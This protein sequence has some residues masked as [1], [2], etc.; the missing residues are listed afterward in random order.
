LRGSHPIG[1]DIQQEF[2]NFLQTNADGR[3]TAVDG[4]AYRA[5][6]SITLLPAALTQLTG[7]S[8]DAIFRIIFPLAFALYPL[9]VF[10]LARRFAATPAAF[11][12]AAII[13][14]QAHFA[15]QLPAVARQ[16][17]AFLFFGALLT[18]IFSSAVGKRRDVAVIVCGACLVVS[19]YSTAY[20]TLVALIATL[21]VV[22]LV[23]I[24]RRAYDR[25]SGLN[26]FPVVSLVLIAVAWYGPVTHSTGNVSKFVDR[27]DQQQTASSS[28]TSVDRWINGS[29]LGPLSAEEFF[30]KSVVAGKIDRPWAVTYPEEIARTSPAVDDKAAVVKERSKP[31]KLFSIGL[32]VLAAQSYVL[33]SVAAVLC[34]AWRHRRG[35]TTKNWD[36]A[37]LAVVMLGLVAVVRV[38]DTVGQ[39]YNPERF[40]IQAATVLSVPIAWMVAA[41]FVRRPRIVQT[42][43]VAAV[44][45]MFFNGSGMGAIL[46]GG[47]PSL[48]L[49]NSGEAY[50]RFVI[51]DDE[52]AASRWLSANREDKYPVFADRYG[53]IRI[54]GSTPLRRGLVDVLTPPTLDM[55]SY[56]YASHANVVEQRARGTLNGETSVYRF[57]FEFLAENKS[58]LYSA[59]SA[60]VYR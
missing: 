10:G 60:E 51:F 31:L 40:Q 46:L 12:A 32:L 43:L 52:I 13:V 59:G 3:W 21:I 11:A 50:E 28:A 23:S 5:M 8:G 48:T 9:Y 56:V 2:F 42:V 26:V 34:F 57:P 16:E 24:R 54:V 6:L 15:Q 35:A 45:V 25:P 36:F 19:H 39:A 18:L 55:S 44:A 30:A 37:V 41:A 27:L 17:V 53:A 58:L 29:G 7:M 14:V 38:S 49:R 22:K 47:T 4:D 20:I 33:L 1:F